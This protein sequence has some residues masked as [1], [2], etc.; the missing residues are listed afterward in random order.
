MNGK[1]DLCRRTQQEAM[2]NLTERE[3]K[4][5]RRRRKRKKRFS[6]DAREPSLLITA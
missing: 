1:G 5:R 6:Y 2:N 3:R 4:R